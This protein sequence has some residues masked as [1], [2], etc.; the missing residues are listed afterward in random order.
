ME[1]HEPGSGAEVAFLLWPAVVDDVP[2]MKRPGGA[3]VE[4]GS[5][6]L[7]LAWGLTCELIRLPAGFGTPS[8]GLLQV[9]R[10]WWRC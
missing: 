9:L 1:Q 5:V 2:N 6:R 8:R 10:D 4:E 3:R 7:M